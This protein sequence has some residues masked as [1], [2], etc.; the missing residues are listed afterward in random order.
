M[1]SSINVNS[2]AYRTCILPQRGYSFVEIRVK[3]VFSPVGAAL[4]TAW[5]APTGQIPFR[6]YYSYKAAAPTVQKSASPKQHPLSRNFLLTACFVFL[7]F[8]KETTFL[9]RYLQG[10]SFL[11][12]EAHQGK[13]ARTQCIPQHF[14]D[15]FLGRDG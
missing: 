10:S 9:Q 14:H 1:V 12:G 6:R 3:P 5:A 15:G 8:F 11:F 4:V 2:N 13:S 7:Q